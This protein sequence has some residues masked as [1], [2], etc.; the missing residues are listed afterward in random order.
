MDIE[1]LLLLQD[2]RNATGGVLDTF[3]EVVS[4]LVISPVSIVAIAII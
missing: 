2:F 3:M 4:E 1:Y